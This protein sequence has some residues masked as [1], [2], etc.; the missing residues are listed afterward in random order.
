MARP[1]SLKEK[2]QLLEEFKRSRGNKKI[3]DLEGIA[4]AFGCGWKITK[5]S[6]NQIFIPPYREINVVNVA[7]PHSNQDVLKKYISRFIYMLGDI[8]D[9]EASREGGDLSD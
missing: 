6:E 2:R 7:I 5:K 3:R 8:L 4:E 9:Y 1:V